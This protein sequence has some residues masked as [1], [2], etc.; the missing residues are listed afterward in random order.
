[1]RRRHDSLSKDLLALWLEPLGAVETQRRVQGEERQIDVVFTKAA[2]NEGHEARR[3]RR[4]LGDLTSMAHGL[5]AIE[6]FRNPCTASELRGCIV[7]LVE[8]HDVLRRRARRNKRSAA[9]APLPRMW[10]L[11]PT[12][13]DALMEAFGMT[14]ASDLFRGAYTLPTALL[15]VVVVLAQLEPSPQTLWLRLLGRGEVQARAMNEL[16]RMDDEHPLRE[17]TVKR[18]LRW[19]MEARERRE[20][21]EIDKEYLMNSERLVRQWERN[22]RR[23]AEAKGRVDGKAEGKAEAVLAVLRARG[24]DVTSDQATRVSTCENLVLLER[25]LVRAATATATA[26]IFVPTPTPARRRAKAPPTS[27]RSHR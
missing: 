15:T 10:V 12:L 26:D 23:Q 8:L 19:R 6:A 1:M 18:V 5:A 13:S 21:S 27:A 14:P 9:S 3:H 17:P 2:A 20:P 24:L 4:Q 22:V 11:T 7:K 25:W 16:A